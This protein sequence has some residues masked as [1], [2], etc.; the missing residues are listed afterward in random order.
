MKG[1]LRDVTDIRVDDEGD[2]YRTAYL[3]TER[4]IYVLHSFQ[5]KATKGIATPRHH[6][7]LISQRLQEAKRHYAQHY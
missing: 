5:K 6:L 2:T 3:V 7:E 4:A 1:E